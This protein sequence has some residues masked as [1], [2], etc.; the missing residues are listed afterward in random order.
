MTFVTCSYPLQWFDD[1]LF[2][3]DDYKKREIR[4]ICP[5]TF[6][7]HRFSQHGNLLNCTVKISIR[8][9]IITAVLYQNMLVCV[10][11]KQASYPCDLKN[12]RSMGSV[13]NLCAT[14]LA[15]WKIKTA[16]K[17]GD[18]LKSIRMHLCFQE[19]MSKDITRKNNQQY[20]LYFNSHP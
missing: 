5:L 2:Q 17:G 9:R 16:L 11:L 18:H 14:V 6:K 3:C 8:M 13:F 10:C 1:V 7:I 4:T 15:T 20:Y 12:C 19:K